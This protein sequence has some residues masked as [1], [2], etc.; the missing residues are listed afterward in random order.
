MRMLHGTLLGFAPLA[1]FV[2]GCASAQ[3]YGL[4]IP[5]TSDIFAAGQS[6]AFS[7]TLP[8]VIQFTAGSVAY[9]TI[10]AAG[11]ITLGAGE[12]YS[13]PDGVPFGG[14]TGLSSYNG[15]SGIIAVDRGFFLTG[16]FLNDSVPSG[17]G[18]PVLNFTDAENYLTLSPELSQTFF[19]GT[20][21]SPTN[22]SPGFVSKI[23]VVPQG[24]TRLFL[25]IADG[26]YLVDGPPGCYD[27]NVGKFEA[28]VTLHG[29]K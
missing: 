5:A 10:L 26:C 27:D 25:G 17:N 3:T 2:A 1:L 14:G 16:V 23:L 20:G 21:L 22:A 13:H 9:V 4:S 29:A 24:A 11:Q 8:P 18:P 15:L 12:P 7:G 28:D 19:I 6:E